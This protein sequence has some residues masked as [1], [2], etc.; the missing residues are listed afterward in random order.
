MPV[1]LCAWCSAPRSCTGFAGGAAAFFF[2][3]E[4]EE[5]ERAIK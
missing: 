2:P 4:V 1:S 3:A 5:E